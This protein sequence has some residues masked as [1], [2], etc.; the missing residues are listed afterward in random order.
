[1][2]GIHPK[3]AIHIYK[4]FAMKGGRKPMGRGLFPLLDADQ[5]DAVTDPTTPALLMLRPP[6]E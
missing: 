1:M 2:A 6:G 3:P 4:P 5:K